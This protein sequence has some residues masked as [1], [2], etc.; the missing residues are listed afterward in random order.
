MISKFNQIVK[1]TSKGLEN[2]AAAILFIT[3]MLIIVN[4]ISRRVF[5]APVHG[6]I[7]IILFFTTVFI[8][9]S[10]A[11]CAVRNGHIY[12]SIL[13]DRLPKPVQKVIDIIIGT[14]SA[15]F[16]FMVAWQ[17]VLYGNTMRETGEVSLTIKFPHYPFVYL[18]ALGFGMLTLVVAGKVL[19]LFA[20][21]E[22]GEDE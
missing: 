14:I 6:A 8:G 15:V 1:K 22:E 2:I 18:Q 16:L 17:F 9:L 10:L 4:V 21:E 13:T 20:K 11:Y 7:D 12:I 3:A 5:N 19:S